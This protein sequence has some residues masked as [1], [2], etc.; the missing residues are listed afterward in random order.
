MSNLRWWIDEYGFDGF[1]F[2]GVMSM[3]YH[4]HG[5]MTSFSGHYGEYFGLSVDTESLTYLMLANSF[6]HEKYPFIITIAEVSFVAFCADVSG[7]L[8]NFEALLCDIFSF[9]LYHFTSANIAHRPLV[10]WDAPP[11]FELG[12]SAITHC[13]N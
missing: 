3:L 7:V 10:K 5:L 13:R 2:D 8:V 1:R 6:L 4:H 9:Y 11:Y 12:L